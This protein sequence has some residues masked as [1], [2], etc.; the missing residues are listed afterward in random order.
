MR[1]LRNLALAALALTPLA[2]LADDHA[3]KAAAAD[4]VLAEVVAGDWRTDEAKA[5]DRYRHPVESLTF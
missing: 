3:A 5:R 4:P 2:S 1:N